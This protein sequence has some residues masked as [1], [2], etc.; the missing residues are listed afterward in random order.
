[1]LAAALILLPIE[2]ANAMSV[3][4]FLGRADALMARGPLALFSSD[5]GLLRNEVT[6]ASA[7]LRA[8]RA[9]A[10]RAGQRVSSCPPDADSDAIER[11]SML[12]YFR[13]IPA[14]QSQR[15]EVRDALRGYLARR[16]PC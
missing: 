15:T 13:A 7:A 9:A 4:S 16:F 11:E 3:A 1:V 8:E 6:N 2:A 10:R 14:V 12:A 5:V